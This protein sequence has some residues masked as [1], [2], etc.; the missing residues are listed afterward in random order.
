M[1]VAGRD[2]CL[3][4]LV[5]W[6]QRVEAEPC[7][8]EE[9]QGDGGG[10]GTHWY[11]DPTVRLR[12]IG[13]ASTLADGLFLLSLVQGAEGVPVASGRGGNSL[14]PSTL[15]EGLS[16]SPS[17]SNQALP[18]RVISHF[19]GRMISERILQVGI[20]SYE[21]GRSHV[22]G[23]TAPF[24]FCRVTWKSPVA[25]RVGSQAALGHICCCKGF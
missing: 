8:S 4:S 5:E 16:C 21:V 10:G 7:G 3:L 20:F 19:S 11:P 13:I 23:V 14:P 2:I 24:V 22:P 6:S 15:D 25:I 1:S 18:R 12:N 9:W 17:F